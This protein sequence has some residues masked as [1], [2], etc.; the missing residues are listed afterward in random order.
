M[1]AGAT[2]LLADEFFTTT[3][4]VLVGPGAKVAAIE[5]LTATVVVAP[6]E[7]ST[8]AVPVGV[9]TVTGSAV[10]AEFSVASGVDGSSSS[11]RSAMF[12]LAS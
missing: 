4:T 1:G 5:A 6:W 3:T 12:T 8:I 2:F 10:D 7:T 11:S 9:R